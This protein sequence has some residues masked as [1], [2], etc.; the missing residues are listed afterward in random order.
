MTGWTDEARAA[1]AAARR[2]RGSYHN[3]DKN[4]RGPGK[5]IGYGGGE[6]YHI[7][8]SNGDKS[9]WYSA[10]GQ[11]SGAVVSG[12]G[13]GQISAK[14]SNTDTMEKVGNRTPTNIAAQHNIPTGHLKQDMWGRTDADLAKDY[15]GPVRHN[16]KR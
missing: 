12:K 16:Q 7:Q 10:V 4:A 14:L 15:G 11:R 2:G 9:N 3:I 13:L 5:H 1:A 8:K 6:A